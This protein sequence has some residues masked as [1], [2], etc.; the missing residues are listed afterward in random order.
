MQ[1]K[2][3]IFVR[4]TGPLNTLASQLNIKGDG[5]VSFIVLKDDA[6]GEVERLCRPLPISPQVASAMRSVTGVVEVQ[7]V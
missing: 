6:R 5:Q 3:R 2:L 4:D 7:L 1:K